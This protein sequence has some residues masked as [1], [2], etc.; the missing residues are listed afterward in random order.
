MRLWW[1]SAK[2]DG[3]LTLRRLRN[4]VSANRHG[5]RLEV[6]LEG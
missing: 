6:V 1:E 2:A 5:V 4:L 3:K